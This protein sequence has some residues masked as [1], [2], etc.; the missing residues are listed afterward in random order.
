MPVVAV[1]T[2]PANDFKPPLS[3]GVETDEVRIFERSVTLCSPT[4]S[5]VVGWCRRADSVHLIGATK[6]LCEFYFGCVVV[7]LVFGYV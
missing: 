7:L 4:T 5:C 1:P 2:G 3:L 6:Q